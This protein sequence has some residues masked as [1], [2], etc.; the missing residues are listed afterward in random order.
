MDA[1]KFYYTIFWKILFKKLKKTKDKIK[2]NLFIIA[3]HIVKSLK[4]NS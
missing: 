1:L 2:L 3:V 4:F